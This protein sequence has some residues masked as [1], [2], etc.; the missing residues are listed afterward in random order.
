MTHKQNLYFV[1]TLTIILSIIILFCIYKYGILIHF[2]EFTGR[3]LYPGLSFFHGLDLYEPKTGPHVTLYGWGM[4]L[5]YSI[6]WV[7]AFT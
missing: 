5:F 4:A 3:G 7:R 2:D 1:L 6:F